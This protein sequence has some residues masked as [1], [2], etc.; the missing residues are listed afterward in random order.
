MHLPGCEA[1]IDVYKTEKTP[2]VMF[3]ELQAD[4][5]KGEVN[6]LMKVIRK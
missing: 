5:L 4:A 3:P 2:I 1:Q 6:V